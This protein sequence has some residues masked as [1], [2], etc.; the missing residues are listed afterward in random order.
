MLQL[1]FQ[2]K[3]SKIEFKKIETRRCGSDWPYVCVLYI[4]CIKMC[5]AIAKGKAKRVI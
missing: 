4:R 5:I 2:L 3:L 1:M